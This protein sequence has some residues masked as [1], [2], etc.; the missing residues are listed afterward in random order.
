MSA[1]RSCDGN[2]RS[3]KEFDWW[4]FDS[5][6]DWLVRQCFT[7]EL[8]LDFWVSVEKFCVICGLNVHND[9]ALWLFSHLIF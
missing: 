7:E 2:W 8:T 1:L 5:S 3:A 4:I 6:F 9:L